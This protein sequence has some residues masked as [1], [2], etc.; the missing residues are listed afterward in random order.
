MSEQERTTRR[1]PHMERFV[2]IKP[3]I[4]QDYPDAQHVFL[5]SG[6]Q[7]FCVSPHGCETMEEAEF[8]R[9]M[10]CIALDNIVT[11]CTTAR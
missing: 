8:L 7:Q 4:M 5:Q 10:L 9:D 6:N 11:E 1:A 2:T 3:V